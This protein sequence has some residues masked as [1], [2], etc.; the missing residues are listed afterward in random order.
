MA[1]KESEHKL[2]ISASGR[3]LQQTLLLLAYLYANPNTAL[4]FDEPDAHLEVFRQRQTYKLI[5]DVAEQQNS[6]IVEVRK[7]FWGLK[8]A[9]KDLVG[10]A[11]FDRLEQPLPKDL[12]VVGRQWNRREIENYLCMEEVLLAYAQGDPADDFFGTFEADRRKETMR[13]LIEE[14]SKAFVAIDKPDPW[15]ADIKATDDFWDP[16]FKRFFKRLEL[17]N[18]LSKSHYHK[19]AGFVPR[20]MIDS[21][22]V[23]A[24]DEI[25]AV[26]KKA[27]PRK[28]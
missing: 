21:E 15:S 27:R 26:E 1:Y 14:I 20:E 24:L 3:G 7:H 28:D 12:G 17:P 16:L 9:K 11:I 5:T 22:I 4:L 6:Q 18:H 13:E 25:V 19:L 2:D 8:Y 23:E 10:I